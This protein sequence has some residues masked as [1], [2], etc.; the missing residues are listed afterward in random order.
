MACNL[1]ATEVGNGEASYGNYYQWGNNHPMGDGK[2]TGEY[3]PNSTGK[4][5]ASA[6]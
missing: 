5:D 6:F 4:I 1:G 2:L 3:L